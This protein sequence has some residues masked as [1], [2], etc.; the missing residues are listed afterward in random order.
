M[1]DDRLPLSLHITRCLTDLLSHT[2]RTEANNSFSILLETEFF[3]DP[4]ATKLI[5]YK[6]K[7]GGID[8]TYN[9]SD[10]IE[11]CM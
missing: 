10:A 9:D 11:L 3:G 6:G 1:R 5:N 4:K 7:L 8:L 2:D